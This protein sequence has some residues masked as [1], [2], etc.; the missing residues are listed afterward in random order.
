M[1]LCAVITFADRPPDYCRLG[2]AGTVQMEF[3]DSKMMPSL[4][5]VASDLPSQLRVLQV[6][7]FLKMSIMLV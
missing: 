5:Q 7:Q 2:F 6:I 4:L 3:S 1:I